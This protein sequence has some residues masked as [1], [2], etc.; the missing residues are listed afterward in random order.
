[1]L[2][3]IC[4]LIILFVPVYSGSG[5]TPDSG[6]GD[7]AGGLGSGFDD[8]GFDFDFLQSLQSQDELG[9]SQLGGAPPTWT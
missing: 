5:D 8:L 9:G 7:Q 4:D 6:L 1:V 3:R 2:I